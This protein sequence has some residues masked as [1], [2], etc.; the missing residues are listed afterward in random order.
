MSTAWV[1]PHRNLLK[2]KT[3]SPWATVNTTS[4]CSLPGNKNGT[5]A[6]MGIRGGDERLPTDSDIVK[7]MGVLLSEWNSSLTL[8]DD[9][10]FHLEWDKGGAGR[11]SV[12]KNWFHPKADL[13]MICIQEI[14]WKKSLES[15]RRKMEKWARGKNQYMVQDAVCTWDLICLVHL[16]YRVDGISEWSYHRVG[17]LSSNSPSSLVRATPGALTPWPRESL[18]QS[19]SAYRVTL[20]STHTEKTSAIWVR[21]QEYLLKS[22]EEVV[23]ITKI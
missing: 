18:W 10:S 22:A 13:T 11:I 19:H 5:V 2:W 4:H 14:K 15:T 3:D 21:F 23:G 6:K 12:S 16:R 8:N 1:N 20:P 9:M 7:K 17:H